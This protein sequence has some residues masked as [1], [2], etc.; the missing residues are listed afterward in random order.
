MAAIS[1]GYFSKKQQTSTSLTMLV[2]SATRSSA[3][4]E[5]ILTALRRLLL[6]PKPATAAIDANIDAFDCDLDPRCGVPRNIIPA[7]LLLR[8]SDRSRSYGEKRSFEILPLFRI[9][10]I[11][12]Q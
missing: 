11:P 12:F 2:K 4:S 1:V 3:K 7:V 9:T 6:S 5:P 10:S 8:V